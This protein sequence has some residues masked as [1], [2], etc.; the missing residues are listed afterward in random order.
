M[1]NIFWTAC[2]LLL[3]VFIMLHNPKSQT[4]GSQSALFTSTRSAEETINKITWTLIV[5]FF[6][7]TII[8]STSNSYF[9]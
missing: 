9:L 8:I 2:S 3:I 6:F 7:L 5:L 4:I 1:L